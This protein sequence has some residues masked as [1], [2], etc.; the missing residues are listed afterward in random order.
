[1]LRNV[2]FA[3]TLSLTLLWAGSARAESDAEAAVVRISSTENPGCGTGFFIDGGH[4]LVTNVHVAEIFCRGLTCNALKLERQ[5]AGGKFEPVAGKPL[6]L[7]IVRALPAIDVA[8]LAMPPDV[9]A[10]AALELSSTAPKLGEAVRMIG[11]PACGNIQTTTGAVEYPNSIFFSSGASGASGSSGSPIIASDGKVTGVAF[12]SDSVLR[13]LY[14]KFWG[15]HFTLRAVRADVAAS[16]R[17]GEHDG[18]RAPEVEA[19]LQYYSA[20]VAPA[21][22]LP[23]VSGVVFFIDAV[24]N[25]ADAISRESSDPELLRIAIELDHFP[26]IILQTEKAPTSPD[27]MAFERLVFASNLEARGAFIS[28]V[29]PLQKPALEKGLLAQHRDQKDVDAV[30]ALL[31]SLNA[32]STPGLASLGA[33]LYVAGGLLLFLLLLVY[34]FS[35]G[36]VYAVANGGR[37][38]RVAITIAVALLVWPLSFIAF[39]FLGKKTRRPRSA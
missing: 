11:F 21:D 35:L 22:G 5:N 33:V 10:P 27:A 1:M 31:P 23:R 3:I 30:T 8:F 15:G 24:R 34:G 2:V 26:G 36:Y 17:E 37:I 20:Y 39:L 25:V 16:L 9:T 18:S 6:N 19:L 28:F 38:K 7:T 4:T 14:D 32:K 13:A 29:Q 12:E